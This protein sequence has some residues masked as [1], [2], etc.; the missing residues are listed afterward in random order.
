M[1]TMT[2]IRL[3]FQ[4]ESRLE[5]LIS[6][7][8]DW[9]EGVEY[10]SSR[11][12]HPEGAVKFHIADVLLN[13]DR[14]FVDSPDR[15]TLRLISLVHDTFKYRVDT[16]QPRFGENHHAM[17][18]RRFAESFI[19]DTFVLDVIELHNASRRALALLDRL[20]SNLAL[21]LAFY[22]CD[23][24][25]AGKEQNCYEWFEQFVRSLS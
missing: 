15:G 1:T 25:T 17:I 8:P 22:R 3:P 4:L 21:Y 23:N 11:R 18:A 19:S 13:V 7:H 2:H 16:D 9:R 14:F 20:G 6:E 24:A 10:G 5:H 12:G